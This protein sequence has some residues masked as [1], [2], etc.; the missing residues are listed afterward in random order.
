MNVDQNGFQFK[1]PDSARVDAIAT[2]RRI[3]PIIVVKRKSG[4]YTLVDGSHRLSY[5]SDQKT[6][7]AIIVFQ[8]Q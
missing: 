1:G 3:P 6:G 2:L 5:A 8:E 7:V 4:D